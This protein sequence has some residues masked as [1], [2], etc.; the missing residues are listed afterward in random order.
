[1][2]EVATTPKKAVKA[3]T[4]AFEASIPKLDVTSLEV[5]A[6]VRELGELW[7]RGTRTVWT[8]RRPA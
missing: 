7:V 8:A 3:A 4:S 6:A 2:V 5:P 1:M